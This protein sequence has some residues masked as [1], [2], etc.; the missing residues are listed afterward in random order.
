MCG[1]YVFRHGRYLLPV[2]DAEDGAPVNGE[3]S[4]FQ[5]F[6]DETYEQVRT[7][8]DAKEAS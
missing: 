5:F 2:A 4:V 8:V 6:P 1:S 3:F 7:F